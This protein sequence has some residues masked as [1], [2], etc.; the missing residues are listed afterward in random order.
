[1]D[2]KDRPDLPDHLV[3]LKDFPDRLNHSVEIKD[4][5]DHLDHSV[6][7]KE[8]LVLACPSSDNKDREYQSREVHPDPAA[9]L[10]L[11]RR[12]P[13]IHP[14]VPPKGRVVIL[15]LELPEDTLLPDQ[16]R[17]PLSVT[18]NDPFLPPPP[19]HRLDHPLRSDH[20][21]VG[22][23]IKVRSDQHLRRVNLIDN[24]FLRI[25]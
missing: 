4:H 23:T 13:V 5:L 14:P 9:L 20:L 25:R 19:D 2:L 11:P 10:V 22:Q 15:R 18:L 6:D 1:M 12:L 21:P 17:H 7:H 16:V 3:D 8:L 24:T